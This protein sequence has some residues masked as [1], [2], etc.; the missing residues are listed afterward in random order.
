MVNCEICKKE[1]ESDKSLHAHIK[2]HKLLVVEYYQNV[3]PRFDKHDGSI[4]KFKNKEQYLSTDFNSRT[5]LKMWIQQGDKEEVKN[6]CKTILENRK[7]KKNLIWTPSQIELRSTMMPPIQVYNNLFGDYYE[8]CRSLGFKDRPVFDFKCS[9]TNIIYID[10]REQKPLIFDCDTEIK[11]LKF[12]DYTSDGCEN[13][14]HIERKSIND[15][16]GTLSAGYDR[17]KNEI[18][19]CVEAKSKMIVLVEEQFVKSLNFQYLPHVY[20]KGT[21]VQPEF[22]FHNVRELIQKYDNIQFLFVNGR[23]ESS[24]ITKDILDNP[25]LF[26]QDLQ[27]RYDIEE[28]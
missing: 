25:F 14:I 22:V 20:Q 8:L 2:A 26:N 27:Y 16:I 1:F 19:R 21:R 24:R 15:L 9:K 6:Y 11:G 12:G 4:I 13:I 7:N 5:N 18:D 10:S 23:K 3:F 28:L 17:F